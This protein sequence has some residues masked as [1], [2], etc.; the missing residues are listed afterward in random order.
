MKV[1]DD[2]DEGYG[3]HSQNL[4]SDIKCNASLEQNKLFYEHLNL[5][6]VF[7]SIVTIF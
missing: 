5:S 4:F 2:D 6:H 3:Y 1:L 7:V